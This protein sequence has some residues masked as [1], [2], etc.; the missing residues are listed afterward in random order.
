MLHSIA[1]IKSNL[2]R[3]YP[4]PNK[5]LSVKN[6]QLWCVVAV[7]FHKSFIL[8][9]MVFQCFYTKAFINHQHPGQRFNAST[10]QGR[11]FAQQLDLETIY[12]LFFGDW[13]WLIH[14]IWFVMFVKL[15]RLIKITTARLQ[16]PKQF[17][18]FSD[19]YKEFISRVLWWLKTS[20]KLTCFNSFRIAALLHHTSIYHRPEEFS[21]KTWFRTTDILI[22]FICPTL[23]KRSSDLYKISVEPPL[24][25]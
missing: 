20:A 3:L 24:N 18:N 13:Y 14:M 15:C 12:S 11:N 7:G 4:H 16:N 10:F 6:C 22:C 8:F 1:F 5:I 9:K 25:P 17:S 23:S 2:L 19:D 21:K